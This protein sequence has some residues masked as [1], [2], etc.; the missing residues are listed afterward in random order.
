MTAVVFD[1]KAAEAAH[2]R[3]EEGADPLPGDT[4][5]VAAYDGWLSQEWDR[6]WEPIWRADAAAEESAWLAGQCRY[7]GPEGSTGPD[8]GDCPEGAEV[9]A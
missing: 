5:L 8:C 9:A 7:C 4:E 6:Y 2:G 1:L 3:A